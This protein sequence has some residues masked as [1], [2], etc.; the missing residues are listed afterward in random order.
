MTAGVMLHMH[1]D[2][3][4]AN[5]LRSYSLGH[6]K[7]MPF[8]CNLAAHIQSHLLPVLGQLHFGWMLKA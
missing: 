4:S 7:A 1:C 5:G 3:R 8:A 6:G 2:A